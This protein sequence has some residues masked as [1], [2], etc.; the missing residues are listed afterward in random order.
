MGLFSSLF[1]KKEVVSNLTD[2]SG[3][4]LDLHSHLIPGIDDGAKTLEDSIMLIKG[5]RQLGFKKIIT[6]PHIMSGGYNNT[7][8]IILS[9]RDKVREAI[10]EQGIDVEFDAWA[11]YY[12]DETI[13]PKIEKHSLMTMGDKYVLVELSYLMKSFSTTSYFYS[14]IT[15]GY[16]VVLAH[17][18]RYPYYHSDDLDEYKMI[19]DQGVFLQLNIASLTGTYGQGARNAA[20]KLIDN[21]MIDFVA[22]DLHNTRHLSYIK[23][24][25]KLPY[26]EKI[27]NY[28]KLMNKVFL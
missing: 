13:M 27:I 19:K 18:E 5:M 3:L 7:P 14:L 24:S 28:D 25:V 8:E 15:N 9:G 12:L 16:K 2:L 23:D 10:K 22:T 20:E 26:M 11:E 1:K 4:G 17:P 21:N 6:S